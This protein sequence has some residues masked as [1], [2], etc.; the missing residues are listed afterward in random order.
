MPKKDE[1]IVFSKEDIARLEVL[2]SCLTLEEIAN[3]FGIST[4]VLDDIRNRQP[5]AGAAYKRGSS[6]IKLRAAS[7]LIKYIDDPELSQA[8]LSATIFYLK[9]KGGWVDASK[10]IEKEVTRIRQDLVD[11]KTIEDP[12]EL[13]SKIDKAVASIDLLI[14]KEG[15][16]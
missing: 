15:G 2:A 1:F 9:T 13:L 10:L 5:E 14:K 4:R 16:A 11:I 3:Q 6:N 8:N 12:N 7:K